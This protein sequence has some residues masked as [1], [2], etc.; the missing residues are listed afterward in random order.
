MSN[1]IRHE[2]CPK[3][4][5]KDNLGVYDDGHT[6]CFGCGYRTFPEV[7]SKSRLF[8]LEV[9]HGARKPIEFK[10]SDH[11]PLKAVK[12]LKSYG[13]TDEEITRYSIGYDASIE[14]LVFPYFSP[15]G[16][17]SYASTRYFGDDKRQPKSRTHGK[18]PIGYITTIGKVDSDTLVF[19]EDP[20]SAIKVGRSYAASPLLGSHIPVEALEL[21]TR[22]YKH[23]GVWLDPDMC[24]RASKA[25]LRG[26]MLTGKDVF[27]V[28]SELDPKYYS[29]DQIRGYVAEA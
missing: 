1:F 19:V 17:I 24:L 22:L 25:V 20:I 10:I 11:I 12:W 2:P 26:R 4:L 9:Q 15:L 6:Y 13:I 8:R 7:N 18:K 16:D 27:V 14:S 29:E 23:V 3:C 21:A 5:S 28:K